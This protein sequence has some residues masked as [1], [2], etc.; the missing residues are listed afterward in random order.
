[1]KV[2]LADIMRKIFGDR[3][4]KTVALREDGFENE[5]AVARWANSISDKPLDEM[6]ELTLTRRIRQVRP[7]LSLATAVYITRQ[8]MTRNGR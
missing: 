6:T 1:M 8:T 5:A 7:D 3:R 4:D 2:Q